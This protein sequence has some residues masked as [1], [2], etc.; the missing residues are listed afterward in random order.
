[1]PFCCDVY[2]GTS[3]PLFCRFCPRGSGREDLL[4]TPERFADVVRD[5]VVCGAERVSVSGG[6][7]PYS[8]PACASACIRA[9]VEA[10]AQ[11]WVYTN[12]MLPMPGA[13]M[14]HRVRISCHGATNETFRRITRYCGPYPPLDRIRRAVAGLLARRGGRRLPQVGIGYILTVENASE[15][16]DAAHQWRDCGADFFD[17]RVPVSAKPP[18]RMVLRAARWLADE[19]APRHLTIS[20][21]DDITGTMRR[22]E[23]CRA[24]RRSVVIDASGRAWACSWMA[25]PGMRPA[26][27]MRGNVRTES[28]KAIFERITTADPVSHCE[29]CPPAWRRWNLAKEEEECKPALRLSAETT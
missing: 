27:A 25:Q 7:E 28:P 13:E 21:S 18:P 8:E 26:W 29:A 6:L 10:G 3:C 22:A 11:A 2:P 15:L 1:M 23:R 5:L 17:V 14:A 16:S 20:L 9:A 19:S 4:M 12:G 24:I